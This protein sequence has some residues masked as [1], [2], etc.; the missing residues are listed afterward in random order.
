MAYSGVRDGRNQEET[1]MRGWLATMTMLFAVVGCDEGAKGG[2]STASAT[3]RRGGARSAATAADKPAPAPTSSPAPSGVDSSKPENV[4]NAMFEAAKQGDDS[5]L[6]G[7]CE[8]S[9]SKDRDVTKMCGLKKGDKD[10]DRF[11]EDVKTGSITSTKAEGDT[12]EVQ[13]TFGKDG[14]KKETI[15][16]KKVGDKWYLA[17]M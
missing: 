3:A 1:T 17:K 9:V 13:I 4:V 14:T 16:L 12:A 15:E 5:M 11:V 2:A 8:E 6:P 10:W 7:L